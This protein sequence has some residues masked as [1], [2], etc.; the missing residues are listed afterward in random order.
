MVVTEAQIEWMNELDGK[1]SERVQFP[2][3]AIAEFID[4]YVTL[5][6]ADMIQRASVKCKQS[7][8]YEVFWPFLPHPSTDR[9]ETRIGLPFPL[10]T[11]P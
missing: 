10:G 11:F 8:V 6:F 4:C 9:N 1:Y 3:K 7:P 5:P 2:A